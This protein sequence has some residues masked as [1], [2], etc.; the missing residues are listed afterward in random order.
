MVHWELPF[1]LL[2][3]GRGNAHLLPD[4]TGDDPLIIAAIAL[5]GSPAISQDTGQVSVA[6]EHARPNVAGKRI[7]AAA[8]SYSPGA[9]ADETLRR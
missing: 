4:F 9:C 1:S 5:G 2:F 7:V 8:V 6:F 3:Q